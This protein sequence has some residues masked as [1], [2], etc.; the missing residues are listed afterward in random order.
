MALAPSLSGCSSPDHF[1]H[2]L[3]GYPTA[4]RTSRTSRRRATAGKFGML[5][6]AFGIGFV[7]GPA[8]GGLLGG[9]DLRLPFWIAAA[10]SLGMRVWIFYLPESLPRER[11]APPNWLKANPVGSLILLRSHPELASLAI[12][13]TLMALAHETLPNMFVLYSQYRYDWNIQT[14]GPAWRWSASVPDRAR[15]T[16]RAF[17]E[18]VRRAIGNDVRTAC[19]MYWIRADGCR[20]A[21]A[22]FMAGIPFIAFGD[23]R[24]RRFKL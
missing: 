11:R 16:G 20:R 21:A 6:A 2:N 18:A 17:R 12:A 7:V 4:R 23:W 5:G 1:R 10:L 9:I 13:T 8:I 14:I 15:R 24:V 22:F 3:I 19:R